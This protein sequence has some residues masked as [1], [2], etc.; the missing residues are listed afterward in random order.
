M[1]TDPPSAEAAQVRSTGRLRPDK[2][3][4]ILAGGREVFAHSGFTRSSIDMIATAAGVSTR[5]IYK[6]F[7]DKAALFAAVIADSAARVAEGETTL[8]AEHLSD[9]AAVQEVEPALLNLATAWLESTAPTGDHRALMAQVH[10]EAAQLDPTVVTG[11][12][13]AGPGRVLDE[14]AATLQRW[15]DARLLS[16]P[17]PA[18]AAIHYSELVS[19]TPGPPGT[20]LSVEDRATWVSAG[21]TAFVRAYRVS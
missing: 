11:W 17:A 18:I 13:H 9:V 7:P 10:G 15:D 8:I 2:H 14:L 16:V 3:R 20:S 1:T 19:A 6:H 4:A 21:V 5:T 12:W